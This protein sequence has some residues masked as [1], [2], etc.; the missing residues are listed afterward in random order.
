MGFLT[1]ML[2]WLFVFVAKRRL[3]ELSSSRAETRDYPESLKTLLACG[4]VGGQ[5][6]E[7]RRGTR[8]RKVS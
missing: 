5:A 7:G 2:A 1:V 6:A 4:R 8:G 3:R